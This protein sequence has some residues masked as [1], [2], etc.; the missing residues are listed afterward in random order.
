MK[1]PSSNSNQKALRLKE[2]K[3][4]ITTGLAL[5]AMFFGAGNILF[6]LYLGAHA[7]QNFSVTALGFLIAAVGFPFLGLFATSLYNGN[8]HDFFAR[9]GKVPG[10]ITI[11]F[12][13]IIIGPLAAM[14]RTE[15]TTF[16]VL[17]PYLPDF[18]RNNAIFSLLY[19]GIVYLLA[20]RE[21]KI[22]DILALFLSPIKILSFTAL[23][24]IG[25]FYSQPIVIDNTN[26]LLAFRNAFSSGYHTM[27]LLVAF[28]FCSIAFKSIKAATRHE[29]KLNPQKM[30]FKA[31]FVGALLIAL[32]YLGFMWVAFNHANTLKG[33]AIEKMITI[34]SST[35]LGKFGGLFVCIAVSCACIATALAL[36]DVCTLYLHEEVCQKKLSKIACLNIVIFI[37]YLMSNLGFQGILSF[38]NPILH[39]L[40]PALIVLCLFNILYK[41]Q[42]IEIVRIPVLLTVIFF[43]WAIYN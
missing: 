24:I 10:F 40:Y 43:Y 9:L 18:F 25:F 13:I 27:D 20:Y 1:N 26:K 5:F 15:A 21:T 4:V 11:T 38:T 3:I 42:G 28:F 36:A 6:P 34:I 31:C 16:N 12:L 17:L 7:G 30:I 23:I 22:V 8:Y 32:V 2:H 35:V 39:I 37:M 29:P 33:H 14:P 19:C 41:W